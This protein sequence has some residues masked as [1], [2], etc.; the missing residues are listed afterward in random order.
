M[1]PILSSEIP[2]YIYIFLLILFSNIGGVG[3]GYIT[4]IVIYELFGFEYR[5]S[6]GYCAMINLAA[7]VLRFVYNFRT[8]HPFKQFHTLI[9]YEVAMIMFPLSILGFLIGD[10]LFGVFPMFVIAVLNGVVW[11]GI[12][13]QMMIK[14]IKMVKE[15]NMVTKINKKNRMSSHRSNIAQ[16]KRDREGFI[17]DESHRLKKLDKDGDKQSSLN[18]DAAS[19]VSNSSQ[20]NKILDDESEVSIREMQMPVHNKSV[21]MHDGKIRGFTLPPMHVLHDSSDEDSEAENDKKIIE[22]FARDLNYSHHTSTTISKERIKEIK[23][24]EEVIKKRIRKKD[25]KMR[26]ERNRIYKIESSHFRHKKFISILCSAFLLLMNII[27]RGETTTSLFKIHQ[28]SLGDWLSFLVLGTLASVI[29]VF[30]LQHLKE[31]YYK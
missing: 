9:D 28:C 5:K 19:F 20:A 1:F 10:V 22:R 31:I 6:L 26:I 17:I 25:E 8:K 7:A 23:V 29:S 18:P 16:P 4:I 24:L 27:L 2:G 21:S 3:G 12:S 14:F 15:E 11:S 30:S 13:V